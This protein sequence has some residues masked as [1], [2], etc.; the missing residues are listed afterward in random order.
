MGG[1]SNTPS[2][3]STPVCHTPS[4]PPS[5]PHVEVIYDAAQEPTDW[6]TLSPGYAPVVPP[7]HGIPYTETAPVFHAGGVP[8]VPHPF[9]SAP[10]YL[11]GALPL[12]CTF[13]VT[14]VPLPS[15]C[16]ACLDPQPPTHFPLPRLLSPSNKITVP[17]KRQG[18]CRLRG[19]RTV[20]LS[21]SVL[22]RHSAK[23]SG[24]TFTFFSATVELR[25]CRAP[26]LCHPL[27]PHT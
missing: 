17:G 25:R 20:L 5:A 14:C 11:P 19:C 3:G 7:Y 1:S 26:A 22:R 27:S 9:H 10:S 8:L 16:C 2:G 13:S 18:Q 12:L 4:R 21:L 23:Q 24:Y 6:R 15:L